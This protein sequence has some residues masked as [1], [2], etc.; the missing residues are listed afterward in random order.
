MGEAIWTHTF[1]SFKT[2]K[3]PLPCIRGSQAGI[4]EL[5][6]K[7]LSNFPD[8]KHNPV[9]SYS[10][11]RAD[12]VPTQCGKAVHTKWTGARNGRHGG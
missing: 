7:C 5:I 2:A 8:T 1:S 10:D 11:L 4:P 6:L 9:T 3:E 12:S